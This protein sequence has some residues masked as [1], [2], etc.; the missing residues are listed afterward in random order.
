MMIF[1]QFYSLFLM[2]M[3]LNI[4]AGFS[5]TSSLCY[6][7]RLDARISDYDVDDDNPFEDR[8]L[9]RVRRRRSQRAYEDNDAYDDEADTNR[10]SVNESVMDAADL[11]EEEGFLE[12]DDGYDDDDE[13]RGIFSNT[14]IPNPLL[15]SIDPDGAGERF[16]EL[17]SD[18]KFWFD[19]FLFLAFLNFLSFIGPRNDMIPQLYTAGKYLDSR[20][21][22][23]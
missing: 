9:A 17:A 16:P 7:S 5:I 12:I 10:S 2:T 20:W 14:V 22:R 3:A 11:L 4:A 8:E 6:K 21:R 1:P 23:F 13:A 19:I 18:P 15:D